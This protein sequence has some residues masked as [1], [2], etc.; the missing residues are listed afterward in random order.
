[1]QWNKLTTSH[2]S[3]H[4]SSQKVGLKSSCNASSDPTC[5]T[6]SLMPTGPL[7]KLISRGSNT[8]GSSEAAMPQMLVS[9]SSS[10]VDGVVGTVFSGASWGACNLM[11]VHEIPQM[12]MRSTK[13]TVAMT[14]ADALAWSMPSPSSDSKAC[15]PLSGFVH[16]AAF[17]PVVVVVVPAVVPIVVPIVVVTEAPVVML[18]VLVELCGLLFEATVADKVRVATCEVRL[19]VREAVVKRLRADTSELPASAGEFVDVDVALDVVKVSVATSLCEVASVLG[20]VGM[21]H[22]LVVAVV[23]AVVV[24]PGTVPVLLNASCMPSLPVRV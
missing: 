22:A 12:H 14:T 17:V 23:L 11:I 10:H 16:S 3:P 15:G 8:R 1:M 7:A 9:M 5:T 6:T 19:V 2:N 20:E 4:S 21:C 18:V 24:V 13:P